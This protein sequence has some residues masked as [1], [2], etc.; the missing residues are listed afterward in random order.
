M[1][2]YLA[3][4]RRVTL[5]GPFPP[6][7]L[8]LDDLSGAE[9]LRRQGASPGFIRELDSMLG[10]GET[11]LEG[12]SALWLVQCWA[13]MLREIEL[14]PSLR[15][16]G[17]SDRLTT[18]LATRLGQR[19]QYGAQVLAVTQQGSGALVSFE[20]AGQRSTRSADR[21]VLAIPPPLLARVS[22]TPPLSAEK[23]AALRA[24][25]LESVTRIW[26]ETDQRFWLERGESGRV[27]TDLP[28]GPVRDESEGQPGVTGLLGAYATRAGARQL[29]ASSEQQ[30][31]EAALAD[32]DR[33]QPGTRAHFLS[34][35][36][37][38]W[39]NEPFQRGAYAFFG[40]GQLR[41]SGDHLA[42]REG[43]CH[44][45]GDHTSRRPGFMHGALASAWRVVDELT[46][47]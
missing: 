1:D 3:D 46:N 7:L 45:C 47:G 26:L 19:V 12:M 16:A 25:Q 34:G 39:D 14:G 31:L 38:C 37:K 20:Q 15:I 22:F 35:A 10:L 13:Q 24:L 27:D 32:M 43:A 29:A 40:P 8:A 28:L 42:R 36:S 9:H 17:G 5:A 11:G 21:V 33:A 30:R 6:E 2:R 4:A 41:A 44:F 23:L 18:A